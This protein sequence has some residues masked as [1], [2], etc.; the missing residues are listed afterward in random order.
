MTDGGHFNVTVA[1]LLGVQPARL[2]NTEGKPPVAL[3][4]FRLEPS[5]SY[6]MTNIALAQEQ[7]IRLRDDLNLLLTSENSW[8]YTESAF[9]VREDSPIEF[10][11]ETD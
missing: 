4:A 10:E 8:R 11:L 9:Q 1:D 3:L 5:E 7:C 2:L 6:D